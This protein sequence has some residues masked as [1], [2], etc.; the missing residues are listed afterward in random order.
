M[1]LFC[2]VT[3]QDASFSALVLVCKTSEGCVADRQCPCL[4]DRWQFVSVVL[5]INHMKC[6]FHTAAY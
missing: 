1:S 2:Y 6:A 3:G 4:C 5:L